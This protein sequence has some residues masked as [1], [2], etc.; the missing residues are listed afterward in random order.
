MIGLKQSAPI[1]TRVA[2]THNW[3]IKSDLLYYEHS[4]Y[5]YFIFFKLMQPKSINFLPLVKTKWSFFSTQSDFIILDLEFLYNKKFTLILY[6]FPTRNF[7]YFL[8]NVKKYIIIKWIAYRQAARHLQ[9]GKSKN[10]FYRLLGVSNH[11]STV[12]IKYFFFN[13]VNLLLKYKLS[14]FM[15]K[16]KHAN[17]YFFFNK[18]HF[19]MHK[20]FKRMYPTL[21]RLG[22]LNYLLITIYFMFKY[23]RLDI[24]S[25]Y[26]TRQFH[27]RPYLKHFLAFNIYLNMLQIYWKE[28]KYIRRLRG[29]KFIAQGTIGRHGRTKSY[30]IFIGVLNLATYSCFVNY[31]KTTITSLF[32]S[33]GFKYWISIKPVKYNIVKI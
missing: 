30:K 27:K 13:I 10:V 20:I 2:I 28:F 26:M 19:R 12:S 23:F 3:K 6:Y 24:F 29:L 21:G 22:S 15:F 8:K 25:G 18:V 16:L 1:S 7:L 17:I 33:L 5:I 14:Y 31:H 9:H 32:G 4:F 11:F